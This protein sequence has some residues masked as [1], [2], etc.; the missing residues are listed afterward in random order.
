MTATDTQ[1]A[2]ATDVL[3]TQIQ[4]ADAER[5][6]D[7]NEPQTP[8]PTS[9]ILNREQEDIMVEYALQ[10]LEQLETE[11]GRVIYASDTTA[12][13]DS[14][15]WMGRREIWTMRYYNHVADRAV[16]EGGIYRH[17]NLTA[18]LSQ[19]TTM[20]MVAR[21][22]NYFFGT[23]PWY[24]ANFVGTEDRKKAEKVDRHSK[25]KFQITGLRNVLEQAD[26]FAFVRGEAVI[27]STYKTDDRVFKRKGKVLHDGAT[28]Q[29]VLDTKGN[30]IFEGS[31]WDDE[32]MPVQPTIAAPPAEAAP[33]APANVVP[34]NPADGAQ[35][36]TE[37]PPA[38]PAAPMPPAVMPTGRKFLR[39]DSRV[40]LPAV[41][42]FKDGLWEVKQ[43]LF[44]GPEA[45]LVF[46]KDF[47]CPLN[48][49]DIDSAPLIAHLYD[50][51]VMKVI[52]TFRRQD[53]AT[54]GAKDTYSSLKKAIDH[55]RLMQGGGVEPTSGADQPRGDHHEEGNRATPDNPNAEI[56][57]VYLTFDADGDGMPEEI[58]L[59]LD[60]KN[61]FP[62]FYDYLD[63]VTPRGKRPFNVVRGKAIDS[64]WWGMGSMEYF[65][66]EQE[67]IDLQVNRKNFRQSAA[68]RVTF[69]NP[70]C[71]IEGATNPHLKLNDGF[72]Y[73]LREGYKAEDALAYVT[74]PE[75]TDDLMEFLEFWMQL[76]QL[77]S[78][79]INAGD[80]EASGMP[81][82][83]TAT[84]IRN[85]EKSGQEMFA[86]WLTCLEPGHKGVLL[87]QIELLYSYIS[88]PELYRFFNT[89]A[90][91]YESDTLSPDEVAELEYD[92][93]IL[94]TRVK[95]EQVLAVSAEARALIIEFY[96]TVMPL[97]QPIVAPFYRDSLKALGIPNADELII[98]QDPLLMPPP[99]GAAAP[100]A[101]MVSDG[102][103]QAQAAPGTK[104]LSVP[105]APTPKPSQPVSLI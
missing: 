25:H 35:P 101:P 45:N 93:T 64:R 84:G 12:V 39:R 102:S 2:R 37:Q 46:Y 103:A 80:Q 22:N 36:G 69:W 3:E 14:Q 66:P 40:F 48:A 63:N 78:G 18:S 15:T 79:I 82:S 75:D 38:A 58:M 6:P 70:A 68:G 54:R 29:I 34:M 32:V 95:S 85:V 96:M 92:V 88:E 89:R 41:P 24:A 13:P 81:T 7:P 44:E 1:V 61:R 94:L 57:E 90:N 86:Q 72:T 74:L 91:A 20:Q 59:V 27:K 16:R 10:Y 52:Q 9:L 49:R 47:L 11:M 23:E 50:M 28:G 8:F 31:K 43:R 71:T 105:A 77:K 17:S 19:R 56:A 98:P 65:Q 26:E 21:A 51:P 67:F 76:M 30:P 5:S 42:L 100:G 99:P 55:I 104:G 4:P 97:I 73:R 87:Q 53:L 60:R 33:A 62:L 83:E